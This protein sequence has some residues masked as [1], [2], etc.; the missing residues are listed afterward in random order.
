MDSTRRSLL[1][2]FAEKYTSL[3]LATIASMLIARMLTPADIGVYA[4]GAVLAGLAQVL[5]DFGVGQYVVAARELTREHL[6]AALAV[7]LAVGWSLAALIALGSGALARF[8]GT[9]QLQPVLL[10][11][12]L[13]FALVPFT[14][15][16]LAWLRRKLQWRAVFCI[17]TS[18]ALTQCLASVALAMHGYGCIGLAMATLAAGLAGLGASL[19]FRPREL[20]WLPR[21]R[22]MR[23][24]LSFGAYATGGNVIDEAGMAA[25]DLVIGRLLGSAEVALFGKAQSLLNLFAYGISSAVSPVLLPL[26][27]AQAR[28]GGDLRRSYLQT[29]RYITALAWPFFCLLGIL[30]LPVLRLLYGTQWDAAAPLIRLMCWAAA[31]YSM[32]NMA[33]YL[34]VAS[35]Q[36]REQARLDAWSVLVRVGVLLPAAMAGLEWAAAA[37]AASS[38]ARSWLTWRCLQRLHGLA[39]AALLQAVW[40]SAL[41]AGLCAIPAL[42]ALLLLQRAAWQL[43]GGGLAALLAWT[44]GLVLLRHPLAEELARL[45]AR[46]RLQEAKENL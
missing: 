17:N 18:H 10:L 32:F 13:N 21:W 42:A 6:R 16:T 24:V 5:R 19:L 46:W 23:A 15:L 29:V 33:R 26:F 39:F 3:L 44:A 1:F 4:I 31:I 34:F 7:S 35:G 9:P 20:P 12:A 25:P 22:G 27:A 30:A 2:S 11:L 37:M 14:A 28:Q 45:A 36:V 8:Y 38:L 41:L 43:L 40:Q